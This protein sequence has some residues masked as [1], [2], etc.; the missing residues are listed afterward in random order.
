MQRASERIERPSPAVVPRAKRLLPRWSASVV[1]L[2]EDDDEMRRLL[3][4]ALRRDGLR[5]VE[6]ADGDDALDWLGPWALEGNLES[7]PDLIVSDIR[8]PYFTGLE[9]LEGIQIAADRIPVILI[10]GFP[11]QET[12]DRA[13]ALGAQ[14]VL[15]KPFEIADFRSAVRRALNPS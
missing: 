11:D 2:V 5:V 12:T 9:I 13:L 4:G 8:L 7:A 3:A 10:T 14:C 1:L 6:A 15:S